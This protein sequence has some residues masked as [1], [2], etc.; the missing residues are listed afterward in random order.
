MAS[1]KELPRLLAGIPKG[2][3]VALS[4]DEEKVVAYGAELQE[5]LQKAKEA[6]EQD[7]AVI[8]V[9]ESSDVVFL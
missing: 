1:V 3:W 7:P 5:V 4:H 8:R 2:A 9:P 6:G